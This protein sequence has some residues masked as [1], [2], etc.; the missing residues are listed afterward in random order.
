[1][2]NPFFKRPS[3]PSTAPASSPMRLIEEFK[4]FA[5]TM[6]PQRAEQEINQLLSSGK[7]SQQE[8]DYLKK[9]ANEFIKF[10]K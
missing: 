3:S 8:F 6:S 10:L 2:S 1:M 4:K 9:A 7:M 5:A